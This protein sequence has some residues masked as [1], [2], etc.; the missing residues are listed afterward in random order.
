MIIGE[1]IKEIRCANNLSLSGFGE[2]I[3]VADTTVSKWEK[4]QTKISFKDAIKICNC[5]DVT[6]NWLAGLED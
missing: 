2:L 5:F 1:R 3:G 4:D 6:L